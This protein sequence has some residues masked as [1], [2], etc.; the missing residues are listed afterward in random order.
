MP[1]CVACKQK[2][3]VKA[4]VFIWCM[5]MHEC[6]KI[7]LQEWEDII[8]PSALCSTSIWFL[9]STISLVPRPFGLGK[10]FT[11]CFGKGF[12]VHACSYI[13]Q[14]AHVPSAISHGLT[15]A[16]QVSK[17]EEA[18]ITMAVHLIYEVGRAKKITGLSATASHL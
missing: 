8:S 7:C 9:A 14:H 10:H 6:R 18:N 4:A 11:H 13:F 15:K 3:G 2:L 17:K 1:A 12:K 5:V 16:K